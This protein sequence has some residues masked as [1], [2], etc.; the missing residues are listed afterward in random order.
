[1]ED[2][3]AR[4]ALR[5]PLPALDAAP[6]AKAAPRGS[7]TPR[8]CIIGGGGTGAALAYDLALRGFRVV[9]IERG[10]LTS[11]T[12]GR[13]HGQL[14]CGARYA[15]ADRAIARECHAESV[16]LSRIAP[17]CVE[18]NGGLFVATDESEA[19][20][21][22]DFLDALADAGIPARA[23]SGDDA[24]AMEPALGS[25]IVRAVQVPDGGFDAFRLP[26]MFLAGARVLGAEILPWHE[27]IGARLRGGRIEAVRVMDRSGPDPREF[28]IEAEYF[29]NAAGAWAG[30]VGAL[31]GAEIP[32]SPAPGAMLAFRGRIVNRVI[33]RLRP[34]GDGDIL[35]PQRGLSIIGST[36]RPADSGEV[37]L[38]LRSEVEFL[39]REA[40]RMV[41]GIAGIPV[42]AAWAAARPLYGASS[43]EAEGRSL[44]RD[45]SV[46]DHAARDGIGNF[47][48]VVGG[49]A[50][51]LRAMA[52]KAADAACA[53][54]GIAAPCRSA[55]F[56]LPSWRD[57]YREARG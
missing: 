8:A 5:A 13:H 45:F 34:P 27:A 14:H 40:R 25:H 9:L 6:R 35:V 31:A 16:I 21:E 46:I 54:M 48:S 29:I 2:S 24:R 3:G 57:F 22:G 52:E 28:D 42:H 15:W 37:F 17:D 10:E 1:M 53:S 18:Y 30:K 23:M 32:V 56:R 49:K 20:R 38:P 43:S 19:A 47:A 7:D 12:T 33:S 44:S 41:P 39:A 36:Q 51:V 11:G 55:D 4:A 50:T 26:M